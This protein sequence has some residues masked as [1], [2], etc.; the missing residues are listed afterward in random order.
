M[1]FWHE[2]SLSS[3]VLKTSLEAGA[4]VEGWAL[5]LIEHLDLKQ[6]L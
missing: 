4:N 5:E 2:I 6:G 3:G 1:Y